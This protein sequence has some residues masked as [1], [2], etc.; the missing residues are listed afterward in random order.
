MQRFGEFV[1]FDYGNAHQHIGMPAKVFGG[2]MEHDVAAQIQRGLAIGRGK[3]VVDADDCAVRFGFLR[4]QFNVHQAQQRVGRGFQPQHFDWLPSKDA[5]EVFRLRQVGK[6]DVHAPFGIHVGEQIVA[7]AVDVGHGND[8]VALLQ[9]GAE[10]AVYRRHAAGKGKAVGAVFQRG[11][12]VFQNFARGV[13]KARIAKGDV[14]AQFVHGEHAVLVQRRHQ[15][16]VV[17]IGVVGGM[18]G[19][20][21]EFHG[22]SFVV[23]DGFSGCLKKGKS[24]VAIVFQNRA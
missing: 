14:F 16:A 17:L 2:G 18:D 19:L 11:N 13:G 3:G 10:N 4:Q 1:V 21:G 7:A 5:V 6:D 23:G 20:G 8:G 9:I 12:G 22:D 24:K 15:G